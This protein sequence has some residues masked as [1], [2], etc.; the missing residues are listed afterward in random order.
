MW[1]PLAFMS[2][3][4][5]VAG[6][7]NAP[8]ELIVSVTI[9]GYSDF[10]TDFS[11]G[12]QLQ[13]W[14]AKENRH[15]YDELMTKF[16]ANQGALQFLSRYDAGDIYEAE[17]NQDSDSLWMITGPQRDK[18]LKLLTQKASDNKCLAEMLVKYKVRRKA[19]QYKKQYEY[20]SGMN[21]VQLN[22]TQ[23]SDLRRI[24]ANPYDDTNVTIYDALPQYI[25]GNW[26]YYAG[27]RLL[28][29]HTWLH[30]IFDQKGRNYRNSHS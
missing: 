23:C 27:V 12:D 2:I 7:P 21:V 15:K 13:G 18:L 11:A 28:R 24:I 17:L 16:E 10:Y 4:Q 14:E 9:N 1:F 29:L 6:V 3:V 8:K 5:T 30:E 19:S 22:A 26:D 20:A 25:R